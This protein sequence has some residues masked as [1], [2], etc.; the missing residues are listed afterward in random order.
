MTLQRYKQK[1]EIHSFSCLFNC[2]FIPFIV[3]LRPI[4]YNIMSNIINFIIFN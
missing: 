3:T 4:I 1:Q 2:I